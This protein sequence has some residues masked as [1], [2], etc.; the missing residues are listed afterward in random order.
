VI[1]S[2]GMEARARLR[3]PRDRGDTENRAEKP[4]D[5]VI[6]ENE[7]D[8]ILADSFPASDAPPW[9]LGVASVRAKK[10]RNQNKQ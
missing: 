6:D 3:R 10:I 2:T 7:I 9:T 1:E 8:Q 4:E 5:A